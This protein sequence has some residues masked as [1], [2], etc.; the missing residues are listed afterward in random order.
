[1]E[2]SKLLLFAALALWALSMALF[3]L[4]IFK[5]IALMQRLGLIE[6]E[7]KKKERLSG[8]ITAKVFRWSEGLTPLGRRFRMFSNDE[9]LE[10]RLALAGHPH[11]MNLDVFYGFRF[12]CLFTGLLI[13]MLLSLVGF[14]PAVVLLL[15][16][17]GFAYPAIWLRS[18]AAGR[19]E[20]IGIDLPDFM[21]AMSV[22]LQAGVPLD[23][24]MK[25]IVRTMDGPLKEELQRFQQ[26]LDIGVPREQAYMRLMNRNQSKPLE[27]LIL[28]LI[29]GS[30]LGVPISSTFKTL[31]EDMRDT[32]VSSVK[33]KAAKAGPKVTLITTFVIL[34]A[35]I[36]CIVGLLVLNFI[37]NPEGIGISW[38]GLDS[39]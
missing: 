28:S 34:P 30:R 1:M 29:Q 9:L 3:A 21:D 24:A 25:Q 13:G 11:G 20:Q 37:Y 22:T 14:S 35:V 7:K 15:F 26:E 17:A 5:R 36:L 31:A 27:M 4:Y 39:L 32:R 18:A 23:P 16:A 38:D 10:R 33:E 8:R 19:Q 12:L 6:K 2:W